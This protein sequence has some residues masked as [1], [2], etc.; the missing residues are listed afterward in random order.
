[1][2]WRPLGIDEGVALDC[3]SGDCNEMA[4][5]GMSMIKKLLEIFFLLQNNERKKRNK[6]C[7]AVLYACAYRVHP[8]G[9]FHLYPVHPAHILP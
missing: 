4:E 9:S 2:G 5:L 3:C 1:M 7:Y 8:A 6:N